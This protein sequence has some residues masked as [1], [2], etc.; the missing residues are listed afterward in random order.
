MWQADY[1]AVQSDP[2]LKRLRTRFSQGLI[3]SE[4]VLYE[5]PSPAEAV[6]AGG[7]KMVRAATFDWYVPVVSPWSRYS[8][9]TALSVENLSAHYRRPGGSGK[10]VTWG[11]ISPYLL[12]AHGSE[13]VPVQPF[14]D[15]KPSLLNTVDDVLD[16][17]EMVSLADVALALGER[18]HVA[19]EEVWLKWQLVWQGDKLEVRLFGRPED[20]PFQVQVVVEE[21]VFSGEALPEHLG[22]ILGNNALVEHIHTPFTAELANQM[23]LVP[24]SFFH[25]ERRALEQGEQMW[26]DFLRRFSEQA[27]VGPGEPI[28]HLQHA[29]QTMASMSLSTATL[30]AA[31]EERVAFATEQAPELWGE[32]AGRQ[33]S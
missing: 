14:R 1:E 20:R 5:G 25:E 26:H 31:M 21:R 28:E 30:A 16:L 8:A 13:S 3:L 27:Q 15:Q 23:L 7:E 18:R 19:L 10:A 2:R 24:E 6:N 29:I 9:G 12:T 17:G 4:T 32:V 33:A 22:D 11:A